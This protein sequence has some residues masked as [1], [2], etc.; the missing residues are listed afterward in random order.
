MSTQIDLAKII[1]DILC[2]GEYFVSGVQKSSPSSAELMTAIVYWAGKMRRDLSEII[3]V[4]EPC[5]RQSI[6]MSLIPVRAIDPNY[7][8]SIDAAIDDHLRELDL[9]LEPKEKVVIRNLCINMRR[10]HGLNAEQARARSMTIAQLRGNHT[11]YNTVFK[12][13][14]GRCLWCGVDLTSGQVRQSLEH[15]TPKHIGDDP[16]DGSNWGIACSSCNFGKEDALAW[17][18][19]PAAHDY[20]GRNDFSALDE[21]TLAHR[22]SVLIRSRRCVKCGASPK[23]TE[24]WVYRRVKTGLP[25]PSN[26]SVACVPCAT[27]HRLEVLL[28]KWS[29]R[30]DV[31]GKPI[32]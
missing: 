30:E 23:E 25:I 11:L 2:G 12:R 26:C 1:S 5:L 8:G 24:L 21:I 31:R 20:Y 9:S 15:I 10:L 19:R 4:I 7:S 6:L 14:N 22:W 32:I 28:P 27:S 18:T 17:A 29:Q 3:S 16:A 13:Q